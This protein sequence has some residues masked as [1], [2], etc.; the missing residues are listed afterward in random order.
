M[1]QNTKVLS[2]SLKVSVRNVILDKLLQVNFWDINWT[3][4]SFINNVTQVI[5]QIKF[6][7]YSF[8]NQFR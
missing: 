5:L 8:N 6:I 7:D 3:I 2:A 4:A 1:V